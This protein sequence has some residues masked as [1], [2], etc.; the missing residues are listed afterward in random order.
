MEFSIWDKTDSCPHG[1]SAGHPLKAHGEL[2][3]PAAGPR[4]IHGVPAGPNGA[5]VEVPR[6]QVNCF[7]PFLPII[8]Y[9]IMFFFLLN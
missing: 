2:A 3:S 4:K 6:G 5:P 7:R 1:V 8:I 9:Q